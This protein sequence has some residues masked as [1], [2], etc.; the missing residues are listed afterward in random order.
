MDHN[1][2]CIKSQHSIHYDLEKQNVHQ[3]FPKK[4]KKSLPPHTH[5]PPCSPPKKL[6]THLLSLESINK[7]ITSC[8]SIRC[9]SLVTSARVWAVWAGTIGCPG[10][11]IWRR[12]FIFFWGEEGKWGRTIRRVIVRMPHACW[13]YVSFLFFSIF[14]PKEG[15]T[16]NGGDGEGK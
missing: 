1:E 14:S 8:S 5:L 11:S 6:G 15:G 9:S 3:H 2:V 10:I 4:K 16:G 13:R 12:P 7:Q